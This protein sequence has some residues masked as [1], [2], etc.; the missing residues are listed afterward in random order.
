MNKRSNHKID[1]TQPRVEPTACGAGE[2]GVLS[3]LG[4]G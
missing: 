4:L 2:G 3:Q 1:A